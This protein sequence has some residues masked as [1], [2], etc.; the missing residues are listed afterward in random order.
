[1]E[2]IN[3]Q[4]EIANEISEAI[5]NPVNA[6]IGIDEVKTLDFSR[7]IEFTS[8]FQ[9]DLKQELAE[10]EAEALTDTLTSAGRVPI[11]SPAVSGGR[12]SIERKCYLSIL[13]LFSRV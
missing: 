8:F 6:G 4:R 7:D 5:S 10:L 3:A 2:A 12:V 13:D 11:H 9:D 1:M